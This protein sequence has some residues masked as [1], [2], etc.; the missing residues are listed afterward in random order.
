MV[1]MHRKY[2]TRLISGWADFIIVDEL[3]RLTTQTNQTLLGEIAKI[4]KCVWDGV[5]NAVTAAGV[6]E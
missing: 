1:V 5:A 6:D 4:A 3:M 2:N